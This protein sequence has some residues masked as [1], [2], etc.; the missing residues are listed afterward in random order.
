MDGKTLWA[1][2]LRNVEI[3]E[4]VGKVCSLG[5]GWFVRKSKRQHWQHQQGWDPKVVGADELSSSTAAHGLVIAPSWPTSPRGTGA[6]WSS[7]CMQDL[8]T[9]SVCSSTAW[10]RQIE[11]HVQA[12]LQLWKA[13]IGH[14]ELN[15]TVSCKSL[16]SLLLSPCKQPPEQR[17]FS[18]QTLPLHF[19]W[20]CFYFWLAFRPTV[21]GAVLLLK[22]ISAN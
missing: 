21:V 2:C 17:T 8:S 16:L 9:R 11:W 12:N 5:E 6:G 1:F 7:W 18:C 20:T 14:S 19:L 4:C 13:L 22:G 15:S 3:T 10:S